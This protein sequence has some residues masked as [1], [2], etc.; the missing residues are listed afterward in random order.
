M[1]RLFLLFCIASIALFAAVLARAAPPST[2][3]ATSLPGT[4]DPITISTGPSTAGALCSILFRG[5]EH[6]NCMQG[7][8]ID[9][10]REWQ[11]AVTLN[12]LEE[13][14][15]PTEA[16]A[17]AATDGFL[18]GPSTSVLLA[19]DNPA[20]NIL[21]TRTQMAYWLPVNGVKLSPWIVDKT[22]TIG[23]AGMPHVM[24]FDIRL[25]VPPGSP[26]MPAKIEMLTGYMPPAFNYW[27]TLVYDPVHDWLTPHYIFGCSP[28]VCSN[29]LAEQQYPLMVSDLAGHAVGIFS[30]GLPQ[31]NYPTIGYGR[32]T[33]PSPQSVTKWNMVYRVTSPAADPNGTTAI[34]MT[35]FVVLGTPAE[36]ERDMLSLIRLS[37]Q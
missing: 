3:T 35:G 29:Y 8:Y 7:G 32:W 37:R 15:N 23:V 36:V 16:G 5:V 14:D 1:K 17:S 26:A 6:A 18:P 31:K 12:G 24:A 11:T 9:R 10:G 19:A 28:S 13:A 30:S 22:V 20:P 34:L 21:H 27:D 2:L 33:F 4:V 25:I